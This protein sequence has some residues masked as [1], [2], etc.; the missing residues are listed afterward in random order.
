MKSMQIWHRFCPQAYLPLS[1]GFTALY[2][3]QMPLHVMNIYYLFNLLKRLARFSIIA[4]I[5]TNQ[6]PVMTWIISFFYAREGGILFL[7]F[8]DKFVCSW[9]CY[10]KKVLDSVPISLNYFEIWE[11]H[12]I[13]LNSHLGHLFNIIL[14]ITSDV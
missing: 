1:R 14:S 6:L 2:L 13:L 5:P 11:S 3:M 4:K 12:K 8:V 7:F 10:S 9:N